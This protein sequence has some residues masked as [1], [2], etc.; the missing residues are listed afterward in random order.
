MWYLAY[1]FIFLCSFVTTF[2]FTNLFRK[3]AVKW[4]FIDQPGER[5]FHKKPIPLMGGVGIFIGFWVTIS[6]GVIVLWFFPYLASGYS[7]GVWMR[8]P[9][10]VSIFIGSLVISGV[11]LWDDKFVLSAKQKL[12]FQF[13]VALF[14][15]SIGIRAKLFLPSP[16]SYLISFIWILTITNAFNLLDNMDGVSSGIALICGF[17]LFLVS[18]LMK[19]YFIS[20]MLCGFM[21]ALAGF[22]WFNFPPASIFM[23]DCGSMFIGYIISIVTI[24]G[25]YYKPSSPT[26]FPVVIPLLVLAVPLFDVL[27]VIF[28]RILH[29]KPIF[30]PDK[31]H[32]SHRLV[33]MGMKIK[34]AVLFLY[35]IAFCVGLPSVLLPQLSLSGVG[36]VFL[37]AIGII[38]I[39]AILEYYG[40]NN[41]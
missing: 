32:F 30:L 34:T 8:L 2:L 38:I 40:K 41:H 21:G 33:D 3:L 7:Q 5:K 26:L 36:I 39:I 18:I 6:A 23:G 12:L 9:W 1:L 24:L 22:L 14:T 35:L 15:V 20:S 29:K 17:L 27:S 11:G 10:L 31:N 25:T 16:F 28:I 37:Q 13:A 19:N 4:K